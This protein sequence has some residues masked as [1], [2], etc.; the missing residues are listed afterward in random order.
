VVSS[1]DDG[2][3][4][5]IK[6]PRRLGMAGNWTAALNAAKGQLVGLLM[7]DDWLLPGFVSSAVRRF[8]ADQRIGV[9]FTNHYFHNRN[10]LYERR[11]ALQDGTYNDFLFLL[12]AHK[13]VAVS[14]TL[15]RTKVWEQVRPLPDLLTADIVMQ[16]RAAL[17]GWHFSY[18][19]E[20]LMAYRIHAGQLSSAE[21]RFRDDNVKVWDLFEFDEPA[22]EALRRRH[23]ARALA[24]RAATYLKV[25]QVKNA[26]TDLTRAMRLDRSCIGRRERVLMYL[27][28]H[29]AL[30]AAA[31]ASWRRS[32]VI[33]GFLRTRSVR[34]N[35]T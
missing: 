29:P 22:C 32:V 6:N 13:P 14:G 33:R 30:R 10:R 26:H 24:S 19:A 12:L 5:Y 16:V 20:P 27:V 15:M 28:G 25:A 7:D 35:W 9:V 2:R 21:A 34:K 4:R 23:L 18:I 17:V 8:A 3:I 11:C 1:L 31:I